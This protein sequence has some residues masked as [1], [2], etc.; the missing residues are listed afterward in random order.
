MLA[1]VLTSPLLAP[2]A[3][4]DP[5]AT[6]MD[7][8]QRMT[9][10]NL[11]SHQDGWYSPGDRLTLV[12]SRRGQQVK[13]HFSFNIPGGWD[14]LWY[15][16]SDGHF[17]ADVDIETGTLKDV[18]PDCGDGG[19][20][21]APAPAAAPAPSDSAS[22]A[23]AWANSKIGSDDYDQAC[24]VF[25]A[26]AYGQQG[27]GVGT[28]Y[29]FY[30]KLNG[31]GKI[32]PGVAAPAGALV[33]SLAGDPRGHVDLARGDG[34]FISGGVDPRYNLGPG[35][36]HTVQLL[37]SPNPSRGSRVLGWAYAPW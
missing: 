11:S 20:A 22:S 5:V 18:T 34:T 9:E 24:G 16:T 37:S 21:P 35:G 17:V 30:E 28:A 12:C 26:N 23:L 2:A 10:P 31:E 14:N 25:V 3:H 7:K 13:G 8:T 32:H 33:F 36:G 1:A 29:A 6:V 4:A 15:R 27:L 19:G